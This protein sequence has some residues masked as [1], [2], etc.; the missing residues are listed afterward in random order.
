MA[1]DDVRDAVDAPAPVGR[2]LWWI[3][4][5]HRLRGHA[6][7]SARRAIALFERLHLAP[8][9][10][11]CPV[12]GW[13]GFRFRPR[14]VSG[15]I[16]RNVA[17]P[18][19]GSLGRHRL[20]V[21]AW[22]AHLPDLSGT[23][24]HMAPEHWLAPVIADQMK[25]V[26]TMDLEAPDVDVLAD[27]EALPVVG[28]AV[29]VVVANDVLEHVLHDDRALAEIRRV[30]GPSG[31]ALIHVPVTATETVEYGFANPVDHGHRRAYGPD[32]VDRM[33]AA[34]FAM[35]AFSAAGLGPA[36]CKAA[37]LDPHD[38]VLIARPA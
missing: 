20:F 1:A 31:L 15:R 25:C 4:T 14:V 6:S 16:R 7:R 38:A 17:C 32:A 36:R 27:A 12:C 24:L 37:G 29:D 10:V 35:S 33:A 26:I 34:G 28:G 22:Q 23:C 5:G 18:G 19:C 2:R 21:L 13:A 8:R 3:R 9:A 11:G 30:L